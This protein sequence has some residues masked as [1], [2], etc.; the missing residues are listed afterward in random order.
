MDQV[1]SFTKF[2]GDDRPNRANLM[3]R[4]VKSFI[5]CR[6]LYTWLFPYFWTL[7]P[8]YYKL[9]LLNTLMICLKIIRWFRFT[10]K[11]LVFQC[12]FNKWWTSLSFWLVGPISHSKFNFYFWSRRGN[13][14]LPFLCSRAEDTY[15]MFF[16]PCSLFLLR[17]WLFFCRDE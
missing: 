1:K 10:I 4:Y 5:M 16:K 15:K 13:E 12:L 9:Y 6:I 2:V 17:A 11:Q 8:Q 7:I 3:I 14:R